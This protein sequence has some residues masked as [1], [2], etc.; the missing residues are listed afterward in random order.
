MLIMFLFLKTLFDDFMKYSFNDVHETGVFWEGT[1]PAYIPM[2][3][4]VNILD[5][6]MYACRGNL[7]RR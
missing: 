6:I 2:M 1:K 7:T 5:S 3:T 4:V